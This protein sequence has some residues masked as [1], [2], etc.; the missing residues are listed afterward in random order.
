M[1]ALGLASKENLS[2]IQNILQTINELLVPAFKKIQI[3]LIDFKVEFGIDTSGR[4]M[5]IDEISPD[6]ARFWDSNSHERL[7]CDLFRRDL[8]DIE[9]AYKEVLTRLENIM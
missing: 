2:D 5:L 3:D 8:G 4:V 6:T 1:E 9:V 7:D